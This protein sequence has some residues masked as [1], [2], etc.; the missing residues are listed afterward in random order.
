MVLVLTVFRMDNPPSTSR[1]D[2][3]SELRGP[4]IIFIF[5]KEQLVVRRGDEIFLVKFSFL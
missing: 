3:S 1:L 2:K 5:G 4:L